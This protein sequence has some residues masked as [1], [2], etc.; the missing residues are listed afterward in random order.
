MKP[1][2]N[3]MPAWA[4]RLSFA[5]LIGLPQLAVAGGTWPLTRHY[6]LAQQGGRARRLIPLLRYRIAVFSF[7]DPDAT[8]VGEAVSA[9]LAHDLLLRRRNRSQAVLR[10]VD[11]TSTATSATG[12]TYFDKVEA[13]IAQQEVQIAVWGVVRRSREGGVV[14]ESFVQVSPQVVRQAFTLEVAAGK[15]KLVVQAGP[16]RILAQ[17]LWVPAEALNLLRRSGEDLQQL[18]RYPRADS[19]RVG[20]IPLGTSYS[21]RKRKADWIEVKS[22]DLRGWVRS[23]GYCTGQCQPVLA[24]SELIQDIIAYL[25]MGSVKGEVRLGLSEDAQVLLDQL[26]MLR[27]LEKKQPLLPRVYLLNLRRCE[28]G[29]RHLAP[30]PG[31]ASSCNLW[32]VARIMHVCW[33]QP[34]ITACLA[35]ETRAVELREIA[36]LLALAAQ[37]DPTNVTVLDNLGF[38]FEQLGEHDRSRLAKKLAAEARA[39]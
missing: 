20:E 13:I 5:T 12:P 11:E 2:N 3:R 25:R 29:S 33:N 6:E 30:P 23:R 31:G 15:G 39:P 27:A 34:G 32:A 10:F 19:P 24:V 8:G 16:D 38:L 36:D 9:I 35:D 14:V 17:R 7:E 28:Q 37:S 18:R 22:K 26:R 4:A 21:L 1:S